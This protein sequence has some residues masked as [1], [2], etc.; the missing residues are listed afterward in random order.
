[1]SDLEAG[2]SVEQ[3]GTTRVLAFNTKTTLL[4]GG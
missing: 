3:A 4:L 1:M 2:F